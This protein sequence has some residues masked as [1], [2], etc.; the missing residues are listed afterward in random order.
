[1]KRVKIEKELTIMSINLKNDL[2]Y[3]CVRKERKWCNSIKK[4][5]LFLF[6]IVIVYLLGVGI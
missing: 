3:F 4:N 6:G 1:M 5:I 2:Y